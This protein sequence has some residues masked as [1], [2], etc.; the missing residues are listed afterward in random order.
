MNLELGLMAVWVTKCQL[1]SWRAHAI[2]FYKNIY[3][4]IEMKSREAEILCGMHWNAD[5]NIPGIM[6]PAPI[7]ARIVIY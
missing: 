4:H 5:L 2:F 7:Y 6:K 3:G 1:T